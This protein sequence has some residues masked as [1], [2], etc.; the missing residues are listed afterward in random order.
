[1]K[2]GVARVVVDALGDASA[3]QAMRN[4]LSLR[5]E[6][7]SPDGKASS[8]ALAQIGPGRYSA[9][10]PA[11]ATGTYLLRDSIHLRDN[12]KLVGAGEDT[13][14]RK[15]P[16]VCSK[17]SAYLGYGHYDISVA[18]PDLFEVGMGVTISDCNAGGFYETIATLMWREGD[19]SGIDQML[20]HDYAAAS[21]E[22]YTSFA[23]ISAKFVSN[24]AVRD[25]VVDGNR[26]VNPHFLNPCRGAGVFMLGVK[27]AAIS[28]V[29][30]RHLNGDA[31]GFQ[32]CTHVRIEDCVMENNTGNGLHPGSGSVGGAMRRCRSVG[33]GKDGIFFCLRATYC[34]C[35]SCEFIANGDH[36]ICI[37][38][39][40]T[41]NAILHCRVANN[42]GAGI[43]FR[44]DNEIM[45]AHHTLIAHNTVADNCTEKDN[46]EILLQ[47]QVRDVHVLDN[48][49]EHRGRRQVSAIRVA[50]GVLGAQV[51][52]NRCVGEF[53]E[54]VKVETDPDAVSFAAPERELPVGP[55][56]IPAGADRHLPPSVRG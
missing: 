37:G 15:G 26:D 14:L 21:G 12:V 22:V 16:E 41:N 17:I 40:D 32:Q 25:L 13:I 2:D 47:G 43:W 39:R 33:N 49:I 4:F 53:I 11:P 5:A 28:G 48:V 45:A 10:L 3:P 27:G 42:R 7:V 31:I 44:D 55:D 6:A 46:A 23:P 54:E 34:V 35:D 1:V 38:A 30:V 20:N 24:V 8:A 50:E 36:G 9:E 52:G 56:S 18:E 29:L 19:L 51:H